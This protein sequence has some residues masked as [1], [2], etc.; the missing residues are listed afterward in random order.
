MNS[1]QDQKP[2]S[3]DYFVAY[4]DFW[5]NRDFLELTV[6]RLKLAEVQTLVEKNRVKKFKTD[7]SRD[8][9]SFPI[10]NTSVSLVGYFKLNKERV[11]PTIGTSGL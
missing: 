9:V 3:A 7:T 8:F 2:H 4:R 5:W 10:L 6:N 11:F 1:S